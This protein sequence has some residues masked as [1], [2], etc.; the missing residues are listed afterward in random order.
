MPS[1]YQSIVVD[2]PT[3]QVWRVVRNFHNLEWAK[4][5]IDGFEVIGE[6]VADQIGARRSL[7]GVFCEELLELSDLTR[8]LKYQI[9][10]GPSPLSP[11][12]VSNFIAVVHIKSITENNTSFVEW[13]ARWNGEDLGDVAQ[14]FCGE[15]FVELLKKLREHCQALPG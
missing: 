1:T 3:S 15:I 13:S 9:Y 11:A 12:E 4:G 10:D 7:N 14:N 6:G 2:C 5:V 8:T